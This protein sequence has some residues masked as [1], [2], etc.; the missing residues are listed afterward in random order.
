M[1]IVGNFTFKYDTVVLKDFSSFEP[2]SEV[3]SKE[4]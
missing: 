4:V 2:N 3:N 1:H